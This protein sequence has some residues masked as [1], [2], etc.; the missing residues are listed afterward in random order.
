M[1]YRNRLAA[2]PLALFVSASLGLSRPAAAQYT[3]T[4]LGPNLTPLALN[5]KG[6]VLGLIG[7]SLYLV[8]NGVRQFIS[9]RFPYSKA[10]LNQRGEV[11]GIDSQGN[12]FLFSS[13]AKQIVGVVDTAFNY[14]LMPNVVGLTDTGEVVWKANPSIYAYPYSVYTIYTYQNGV[15]RNLGQHSAFSVNNAGQIAGGN[16]FYSAG[17]WQTSPNYQGGLLINN[18]G[19]IITA[20]SQTLTSPNLGVYSIQTIGIYTIATDTF[21][22]IESVPYNSFVRAPN[23]VAF[24]DNGDYIETVYNP[25]SSSSN[26]SNGQGYIRGKLTT[27]FDFNQT[28]YRYPGDYGYAVALNNSGQA[29]AVNTVYD[30]PDGFNNDNRTALYDPTANTLTPLSPLFLGNPF[31]HIIAYSLNDRGQ[32]I[33]NNYA[34]NYSDYYLATPAALL[35]AESVSGVVSLEQEAIDAPTQTVTFEFRDSVSNQALFTRT[36]SV[37]AGGAFTVSGVPA[38]SYNVRVKSPKNLAKIVA[39]TKASGATNGISVFLPGG[40]GNNDNSVDSTDFGL[41]IGAYGAD[42]NIPGSGYDPGADFN[43]DRMVDSSD[44]GILIGNFGAVGAN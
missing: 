28:H 27:F 14:E 25:G 9:D 4:D 8:T 26:Y 11:A 32:I 5:N 17:V 3:L 16:E 42:A 29:L 15:G 37:E 44:F 10:S 7:N 12:V 24:N 21:A 20:S 19:Q 38:G 13:G 36:A 41:F 40:D 23:V 34:L 39:V 33:L 30:P 35:P 2:L 18:K 22:A 6:Q 43:N 31:N 1:F